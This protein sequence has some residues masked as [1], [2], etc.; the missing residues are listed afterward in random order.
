MNAPSLLKHALLLIV[1]LLLTLSGSAAAEGA[2]PPSP[3]TPSS[4]EAPVVVFN[5]TVAVLRAPLLGIAPPDRARHSQTRLTELFARPGPMQI[6]VTST[7]VGNAILVN[8]ALGLLIA[9]GDVD[10]L[11]GET[12]EQSTQAARA[13]VERVALE[14]REARDRD[15]LWHAL[16]ASGIA[17]LLLLL[18]FLVVLQTRAWSVRRLT[19]LLEGSTHGL[20]AGGLQLLHTSRLF[21]VSRA[22]VRAAA[23]FVLLLASYRWLSFVLNQFPYTRVWG[24]QLDGYLLGV[25]LGFGDG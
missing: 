10:A 15:R 5:R 23:S 19:R 22:L 17:T 8:G 2:A 21:A 13:A 6:S 24:E 25:L 4:V 11:D 20:T 12:L 9:P 18:I 7:V 16:A 1:T 14:T 3:A